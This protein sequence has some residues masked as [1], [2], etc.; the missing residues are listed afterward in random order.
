VPVRV[1]I[2]AIGVNA[3]LEKLHLAGDGTLQGPRRWG[4]AGWFVD[5][6]RPGEPGPAVLAG[7]VDSR[8]GPAVFYRLNKLRVGDRVFVIA[9]SGATVTY[10]VDARAS[11]PKDR[12]PSS[13]VYGP[14]P[15]PE[16]R[17]ITCTGD[18]D[19]VHHNYLDNLVVSAHLA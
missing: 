16:L 2:P 10:V 19:F 13:L 9:A 6:S 3:K 12:F 8:T 15:L 4:E 1:S 11:Y 5:S 17:L 7:H 18:F 14:T